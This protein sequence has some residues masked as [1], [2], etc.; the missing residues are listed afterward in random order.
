MRITQDTT[1]EE[2][3]QLTNNFNKQDGGREEEDGRVNF[4]ITGLTTVV[5]G[6]LLRY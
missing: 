1:L 6:C 4:L 3:C 5:V 2:I